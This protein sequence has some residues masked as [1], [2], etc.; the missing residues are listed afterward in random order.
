MRDE[1]ARCQRNRK[2]S[3]GRGWNGQWTPCFRVT[4]TQLLIWQSGVGNL[5]RGESNQNHIRVSKG[6]LGCEEASEKLSVRCERRG[7]D[8]RFREFYFA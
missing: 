4:Q 5:S 7:R 8:M 2:D 6:K 3:A 1:R